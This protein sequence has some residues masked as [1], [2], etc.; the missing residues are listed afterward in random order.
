[1]SSNSLTTLKSQRHCQPCLQ[2]LTIS[3]WRCVGLRCL[4]LQLCK[5]EGHL[6]HHFPGASPNPGCP[7][8]WTTSVDLRRSV[9]KAE[10]AAVA[11]VADLGA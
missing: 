2:L 8:S 6:G 7:S 3:D 10:L 9:L 5:V 4:C 11:M 1:M